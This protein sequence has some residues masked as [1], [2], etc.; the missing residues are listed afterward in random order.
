[1][2]FQYTP[3]SLAVLSALVSVS[4]YAAQ[5]TADETIVVTANAGFE[6]KITDA[7]ASV[8]V[9]S[10]QDL[11]EKNYINLGEALSGI[12]GVDVRSGTGK[13][14]GLNVSIR[15]M[16]SDKTLVLVDGIRQ[17]ASGDTTP[18]GFSSMNSGFIP[19]LAA[20][21][22]IE[23]IRGPMSTIYGS[24]AMGGVINIITKRTQNK[25]VGTVEAGYGLQ[26]DDKFGDTSSLSFNTSGPLIKDTLNLNL[27][28]KVKHRQGS[29][30]T[31]LREGA[32]TRVPYQ[33]ETDNY[34]VG[35]KLSYNINPQHT[36]FIDASIARQTFDNENG[37]LGPV[38]TGGGGY[39]DEMKYNKDQIIL[40]QQSD[41]SFGRLESDL[42]YTATETKGRVLSHG[43]RTEN[44]EYLGK[45][46]KLENANTILNSKLMTEIGD[47]NSATFGLQYWHSKVEDGIVLAKTGESF[48]ED[49]VSVFAEDTWRIIDP[50]ALTLGARYEHHEEFGSHVSP[51]AYLVWNINS[52]WTMKG[53][54]STGYQTPSL[55]QLHDGI[56]GV[57]GGGNTNVYG[58]PDLDPEE[59]TNYETGIYYE[60]I[61][62][63]KANVTVFVNHYKNA[64][65]TRQ[66][67]SSNNTYENVGKANIHGVE[68]ATSFP[69]FS[70]DVSVNL[71]Y[72]YTHSEQDGGDN[73]GAPFGHTA[74]HMANAKLRWQ[75]SEQLSSWLSAEYYG[76]TPRYTSKRSN[77][78]A[79]QQEILDDKGDIQAWTVVNLGAAYQL[80]KDLK[81]NGM[82]NNVLDKDFTDMDVY[83]SGRGTEYAG[84][85]YSTTRATSGYVNPGRNYWVSVNYTF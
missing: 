73:D 76:K 35:G 42:S 15:G 52:D 13:T 72:T 47:A 56:S 60:N 8:S 39:K 2:T 29:S 34:D 70:D 83:G 46:R 16:S 71:N 17:S 57:T 59:S 75:L 51:R 49:S 80:T 54:V 18:N 10:Q 53:G 74:K 65:T 14:G 45:D 50:L 23:V 20:I 68:V 27:R 84:D 55:A 67:D 11:T 44:T 61:D 21:D 31:T 78:S 82:V 79:T 5:S 69:L 3:L 32:S 7:P 85:Y 30:V 24:D 58:N 9:I 22:H 81:V 12:E 36:V 37:Q 26:E 33:T 62:D 64:I 19:P 40:G 38:G 6:S 1:M 66:I 63:F 48:E 43:F 77:L 28:G 41:L 4:T 25:W